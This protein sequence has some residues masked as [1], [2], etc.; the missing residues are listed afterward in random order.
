MTSA[1][2]IDHLK[3][4]Y[5]TKEVLHDLSLTIPQGEFFGLLGP[6][7]A[8]KTTTIHCIVGVNTI[9]GGT[10]TVGGHDV[11]TEYR[12]ARKKI[13]ISPQEFNIDPF[14]TVDKILEYVGGYYGMNKEQRTARQEELLKQFDLVDQR[15]KIFR[16]LSGGLKRRVTIARALMHNPDILILDE[17]TAGVDVESRRE[18]WRYLRELNQQ[19]KTILLT[20]HY[21]EEVQA[22]TT[23]IG[24]INHGTLAF[25]GDTAQFADGKALEEKYLSLTTA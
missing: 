11:I 18:I 10:I 20:S 2:T 1:I 23:R 15:K 4:S 9:T 5:K 19:G 14:T 24:I 25:L 8:G 16:T 13:G 7:G 3:K 6:N 12:E 22:L 21:L 17:P